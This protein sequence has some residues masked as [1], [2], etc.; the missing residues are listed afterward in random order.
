MG[1]E[2]SFPPALCIVGMHRSG[3][4]LISSWLQSGG[5]NIGQRLLEGGRGNVK[6]HFEDLDFCQF[7]VQVL[8][9][10]GIHPSGFTLQ[11]ELQ[12][13]EQHVLAARALVEERRRRGTPWGWKDPRS[14]LFLDFWGQMLPEANFLILFR[15]PWDVADSLF[16]RGDEVFR[17]NPH[18]AVQVWTHYNRLLL[19]FCDR[20]SE[21][22]LCVSVYR[23]IE[24]PALLLN[25]LRSKF[26][27]NLET[28]AEL[29][30][31][32]LLHRTA[33]SRW[34]SLLRHHDPEAVDLYEHL[35]ARADQCRFDGASLA[36]EPATFLPIEDWA[37][38]D[39]LNL[40]VLEEQYQGMRKQ[41]EKTESELVL[42]R[43]QLIQTQTQQA[44]FR[45]A[46]EQA[47]RELEQTRRELE[48]TRT[49]LEQSQ[50]DLEH[51]RGQVRAVHEQ[52][53]NMQSSKFWKLRNVW[54][55]A[56]H[57]LRRAA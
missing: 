51:A 3:T 6:G 32:T 1:S 11:R 36:A 12:I 18:F 35:N 41:W 31:A 57:S 56:K 37:F 20:F 7:H 8:E 15:C 38:Q 25:V 13:R 54:I 33:S 48:K 40:R 29:F 45:E 52:V 19:D 55:A 47:R 44:S 30:D 23:A 53:D 26:G 9:S 14:A 21:R 50:A 49:E 10:Q 17:S 39:W 43:N 27:L 5:L 16:R 46:H 28:A 24:A 34:A 4:S 2:M 22:C 42:M